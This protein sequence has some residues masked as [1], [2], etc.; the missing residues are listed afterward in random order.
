MTLDEAAKI[1]AELMPIGGTSRECEALTMYVRAV[2]ASANRQA[3][4]SALD[5]KKVAEVISIIEAHFIMTFGTER[6]DALRRLTAPPRG[7]RSNPSH[8][9]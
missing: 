1:V 2:E 5:R 6:V 7:D 8:R 3:E 4:L 9:D